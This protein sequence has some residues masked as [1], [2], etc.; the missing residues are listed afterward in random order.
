MSVT[1]TI[2]PTWTVGDRLRKSRIHAGLEQADIARILGVAQSAIAKWERDER[3]PRDLLR[4]VE[5]WAAATHVPREWLLW[6]VVP[7]A[8]V[9]DPDLAS[10][11]HDSG[12]TRYP[13]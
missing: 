9:S 6:G 10:L 4:I 13:A 2:I 5:G 12:E 7:A 11:F 8:A 3:K 1:A